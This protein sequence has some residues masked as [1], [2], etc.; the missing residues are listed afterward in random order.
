MK[1]NNPFTYLIITVILLSAAACDNKNKY[2]SNTT[3]KNIR[4]SEQISVDTI[5][6]CK[7]T[8]RKQT[9]CNGKLSAVVKSNLSFHTTGNIARI[10]VRNGDHISQGTVLAVLDKKAAE[11]ELSKTRRAMKKAAI[12]LTDK[13]IGQGYN[14][15][16]T[17]VPA[18]ILQ[19]MKA[20]SGYDTS[21][22]QLHTAEK[23]KTAT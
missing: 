17:A 16:T 14:A 12:D 10:L 23:Q 5:R 9:I 3:E 19:N 1:N 20:T 11:Q 8:F 2:E 7:K 4:P 6:L 13:L 15:D 22:D 21:L 18:T